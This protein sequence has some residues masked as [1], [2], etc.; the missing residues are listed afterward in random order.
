MKS[1]LKLLIL[2]TFF[3]MNAQAGVI[4]NCS[5]VSEASVAGIKSFIVNQNDGAYDAQLFSSNA[6]P[7]GI[8][9]TAEEINKKKITLGTAGNLTIRFFWGSTY[10][11]NNAKTTA[12]VAEYAPCPAN[13]DECVN[14]KMV[15]GRPSEF[16]CSALP[17]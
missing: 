10:G 13:D 6:S 15:G 8:L 17:N 12:Y 5:Q 4:I 3:V 11:D 1:F 7:R 16:K 2:P 9:V 14:E